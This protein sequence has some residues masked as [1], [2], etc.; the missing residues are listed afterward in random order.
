[1]HG[2]DGTLG[3]WEST[4]T[5]AERLCNAAKAMIV[6]TLGIVV[7]G[8]DDVVALEF[9]GEERCTFF[10][11]TQRELVE[12]ERGREDMHATLL[13]VSDKLVTTITEHWWK[14]SGE[15]RV[16]SVGRGGARHVLHV[17]SWSETLAGTSEEASPVPTR[18]F[19]TVSFPI[20][21]IYTSAAFCIDR[22]R[23]S[24]RTPRR[25]DEVEECL[26]HLRRA[27]EWCSVVQSQLPPP[28][29]TLGTGV[30]FIPLVPLL[31]MTELKWES[32]RRFHQSALEEKILHVSKGVDQLH[33]R[34]KH[35]EEIVSLHASGVDFLER[36]LYQ[37][38]TSV[39]GRELDSND[40][41]KFVKVR[42]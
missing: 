5:L 11:T 39:L 8:K 41:V 9:A 4:F 13:V 36:T 30:S 35:V 21:L 15:A 29:S 33:F 27:R 26:A 12:W 19:E 42:S 16:C 23:D 40:F 25:N 37:A 28:R 20:G 6:D 17:V 31:D 14:R 10:E 24:C 7:K 22:S 2:L 18:S 1:M 34:L 38:L 32:L 3:N